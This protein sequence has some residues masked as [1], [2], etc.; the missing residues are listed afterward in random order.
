MVPF[1]DLVGILVAV[2]YCTMRR[3]RSEFAIDL[4]LFVSQLSLEAGVNGELIADG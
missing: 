2:R 4:G 3:L 1:D